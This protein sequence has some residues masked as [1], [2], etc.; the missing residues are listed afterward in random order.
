MFFKE[1]IILYLVILLPVIIISLKWK[2]INKAYKIVIFI[3][4][5]LSN[6]LIIPSLINIFYLKPVSYE[7]DLSQNQKGK[8]YEMD[9]KQ[10]FL[11]NYLAGFEIT[12]KVPEDI[13]LKSLYNSSWPS[14]DN[15]DIEIIIDNKYINGDYRAYN[16]RE[17]EFVYGLPVSF[18]EPFKKTKLTYKINNNPPEEI[19]KVI[20]SLEYDYMK[21]FY[22]KI[23]S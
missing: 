3:S 20:L 16:I 17:G 14:I 23:Y 5:L 18:F 8:I 4:F 21:D 9:F 1:L 6:F 15:N 22:C 2:R 19:K 7:I 10:G 12:H 13:K 11:K